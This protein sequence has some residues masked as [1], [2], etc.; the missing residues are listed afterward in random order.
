MNHIHLWYSVNVPYCTSRQ[1]WQL[2]YIFAVLHGLIW[3][4]SLWLQARGHI[5]RTCV[6]LHILPSICFLWDTA[7]NSNV[8]LPILPEG[9]PNVYLLQ[10][11]EQ[12]NRHMYMNMFSPLWP[13][14][15]IW[16]NKS[17]STLVQ[18]MVYCLTVPCHHRSHSDLSS[19]RPFA[20]HLMAIFT[21]ITEDIIH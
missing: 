18:V 13:K 20:I 19:T 7:V 6:C 2:K 12:S 15:V 5:G 17:G 9:T 8:M 21:G 1:K 16:W 14:D 10:S 3:H 4:T 11:C